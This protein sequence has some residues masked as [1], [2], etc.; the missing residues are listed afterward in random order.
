MQLLL[1][2][3]LLLLQHGPAAVAAAVLTVGIHRHLAR[4]SLF[5]GDL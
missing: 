2:L 4:V 3:L 1:L 5:Q